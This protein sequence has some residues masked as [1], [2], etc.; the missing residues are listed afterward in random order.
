M[1]TKN[2]ITLFI[3]LLSF[4]KFIAQEQKFFSL[5]DFKLENGQ[6]IQDCKIGYRTIGA[7]NSDSSNVIIYPTWFGG[8][9]ENILGL[10]GKDKFLDSTGFFIIIIDAFGN[11]ISSSPSNSTKQPKNEFPYFSI[12]DMVVAQYK[13]LTQHFNLKKVFGGIGGS[14]G[15]FQIFE[16][17]VTYPDFIEKAIV[18]V[19]SPKR[20]ASDLLISQIQI[21]LIEQSKK[22][23]I[24]DNETITFL[25]Q[26][27][28]T[29]ARSPDWVS[30]NIDAN[31]FSEYISKFEGNSSETFTIENWEYQLRA[32]MKHDIFKYFNGSIE[33]TAKAIKAQV[34]MIV[35]L[36]DHLVHPKTAID[37]SEILK[38]EI[39]KLDNNCG[40]LAIGCEM[41]KFKKIVNEFFTN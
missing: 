16:W 37:F 27:Q 34:L 2:I 21:N 10:I 17:L 36:S 13:L 7:F 28:E 22:Y 31:K 1:K 14:M 9:S 5:G 4:S 29:V 6:I 33:E 24:P 12:H 11:G 23:N 19:C 15:S 26:T 41:E 39:I 38:C 40:H 32:C 25:R 30:E 3:A 8:T 20:T 35:S 18:Y